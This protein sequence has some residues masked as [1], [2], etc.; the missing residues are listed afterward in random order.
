MLFFDSVSMLL[1]VFMDRVSNVPEGF[2]DTYNHHY[3]GTHFILSIFVSM[4]RPRSIYV[5]S[6]GSMIFVFMLSL[7]LIVINH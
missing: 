2:L 6:L 3:T 5:V 7:I 4:S 1:N